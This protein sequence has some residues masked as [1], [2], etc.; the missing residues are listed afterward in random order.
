MQIN[1]WRYGIIQHLNPEGDYFAV[2]KI[3][4]NGDNISWDKEPIKIIAQESCEIHS[5]ISMI[6]RDIQMHDIIVVD[7]VTNKKVK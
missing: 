4:R 6:A 5:E 7:D 3:H 1:G 2:H